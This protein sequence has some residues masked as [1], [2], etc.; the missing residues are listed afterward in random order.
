MIRGFI[1]DLDGVY[2]QRG[3]ENFMKNV[4]E[5]FGAN[6]DKLNFAYKKSEKMKKYKRGEIS[7]DEFWGWFCEHLWID[8]N[9]EELLEILVSGYFVNPLA[10]LLM[11][12]LR[13]KGI[14]LIICSNNFRERI[15]NLDKKFDFLKNFDF[16]VF[17]Y[18]YGILKPELLKKVVEVT[19]FEF[20]EIFLA[21]DG[22]DNIRAAK[23]IGFEAVYC[24][25]PENLIQ[26]LGEK[27]IID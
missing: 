11:Q 17:S 16:V 4:V 23:E 24:D 20:N 2:F 5:K 15:E 7:G 21:D 19:G 25:K 27:K 8:S 22:E 6:E 14:K 9:K 13:A 1:F 18:E 26:I 12:K 10:P 3:T